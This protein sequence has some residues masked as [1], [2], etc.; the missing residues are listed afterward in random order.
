V[1]KELNQELAEL[2]DDALHLLEQHGDDILPLLLKY[3]DDAVDIVN[4]YGDEGVALLQK[5]G[6]DAVGLVKQ[7]GTPAVKVLTSVGPEAAE[8]LLK[9]LDDDVLDYAIKEGPDAVE[10]LSLWSAD[11]LETHGAELA[12]RAKKDAKV[13]SDVKKLIALGPID[14]KHLT[15]EQRVL[16]DAIAANSTQYADEGQVVL[17]KWVD[18]SNGFVE[19]AQDTG[20]VHYNPHPEMWNLL[21]GLGQENQGEVAWLINQQVVQTGINNG[22][23]F[24][25]TL[26]GVPVDTINKE[27]AAVRAIFSGKSDAE[28]MDILQLDYMPIR[29]KEIQELEKAGYEFTFDKVSNSYVLVQQ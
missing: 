22:L 10:A 25:Y 24:E 6:D 16:I 19:T 26:N 21:G 18:I 29:M 20:S 27:Q 2:S 14:P 15:D 28:I 9:T 5:Y 4:A 3:Q 23:P 13:L 7:Y 17:G 1:A 12:L 8:T 11:E